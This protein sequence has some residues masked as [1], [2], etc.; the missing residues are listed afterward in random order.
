MLHVDG[1][2]C[3]HSCGRTVQ[4]ALAAVPGVDLAIV[5]FERQVACVHG[6][7]S[8]TQLVA[9]V[10]DVGFDA[11][12]L[13]SFLRLSVLGMMCQHSCGRTVQ[14]ALLAV[15][16]VKWAEA[17]FSS[18]EALVW[19]SKADDDG[20]GSS[21]DAVVQAVEDVGF[22]ASLLKTTIVNSSTELKQEELVKPPKE[23]IPKTKP[24]APSPSIPARHVEGVD[25]CLILRV[26]I[27]LLIISAITRSM[28]C[29]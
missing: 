20:G 25:S 7:A 6:T 27:L 3:Q 1:M 15:P 12:D 17:I 23:S 8:P 11:R 5:D 9:A 10:E 2:M 14:Q 22:E 18:S 29:I 26:C 19:M 13:P 21:L 4:Q 24:P 28:H 16:G